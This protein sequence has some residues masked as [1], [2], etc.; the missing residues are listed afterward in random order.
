MALLGP[1]VM[2]AFAPLS[3]AQRTSAASGRASPSAYDQLLAMGPENSWGWKIK[4]APWPLRAR[5]W[6]KATS[7]AG[8]S[9]R[10]RLANPCWKPN[11]CGHE[12][13]S[14][15]P[16]LHD[17]GVGPRLGRAPGDAVMRQ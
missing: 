17:D 16:D 5:V 7:H 13:Q 8:G 6:R 4:H 11:R 10:L 15:L 12:R 14:N 2:S 3:G 9:M 1:P